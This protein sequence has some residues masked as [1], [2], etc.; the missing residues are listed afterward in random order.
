MGLWLFI[1]P[2]LCIIMMTALSH[3]EG[4]S[5]IR[6][7]VLYRK[8]GPLLLSTPALIAPITIWF[9]FDFSQLNI[10]LLIFFSK[11]LPI[12]LFQYLKSLVFIICYLSLT[13]CYLGD[14]F[15]THSLVPSQPLKLLFSLMTM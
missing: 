8:A 11:Q 7:H 2:V 13:I 15:L 6:R 5:L 3:L 4:V 10:I 12:K 9:H 14:I 1:F